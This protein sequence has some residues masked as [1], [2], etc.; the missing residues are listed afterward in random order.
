M[1]QLVSQ[2]V[3]QPVHLV[4]NYYYSITSLGNRPIGQSVSQS[5]KHA[6]SQL[7]VSQSLSQSII[8]SIS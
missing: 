1:N 8:Q 7:V 6:G 2:L 4:N 3:N 5:V